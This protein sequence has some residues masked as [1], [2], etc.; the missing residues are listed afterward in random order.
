M[1]ANLWGV[2]WNG[3]YAVIATLSFLY[4]FLALSSDKESQRKVN[5][6][7]RKFKKVCHV[8]SLDKPRKKSH[9]SM[10]GPGLSISLDPQTWIGIAQL[11][12]ST[13]TWLLVRKD[14]KPGLFLDIHAL[15]DE[16]KKELLEDAEREGFLAPSVLFQVESWDDE[17]EETFI[18]VY[19]TFEEA[20]IE[21]DT[22]YDEI[23]Q[24]QGWKATPV[25]VGIWESYFDEPFPLSLTKEF[26]IS[27][28]LERTGKLDGIWWED[29]FDPVRLS[30]PRG[31]I[32][33]SRI[34]HW[35]YNLI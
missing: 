34:Q 5:L 4:S 9:S 13:G 30:A 7:I 1:G 14:R 2:Y 15:S 28:L 35:N 19:E 27:A 18:H 11:G 6:P 21:H 33:P 17:W 26:A 23:Q 12:E 8:G 29:E 32:F 16:I 20:E 22:E 10:E 25:L 31:V 3:V 24:V